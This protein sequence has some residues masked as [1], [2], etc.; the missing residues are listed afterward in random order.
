MSAERIHQLYMRRAFELALNGKGNVATNPLVGAVLVADEKIIGEG[1]FSAFGNPHAEVEAVRSV[2]PE[3]RHLIASSTLYVSLE[4][5]NFY[6]KTPAC[7][8]LILNHKIPALV[9]STKDFTPGLAGSSLFFLQK[10]GI[11]VLDEILPGMGAQ[12]AASRNTVVTKNRPF[13]TLKWALSTDGFITKPDKQIAITSPTTQR[14]VHKLRKENDA[15]L[16]GA[17][18]ATVDNPR[19][20]NRLYFGNHPLRVVIDPNLRV[21]MDRHLF[22]DGATTLLVT[23]TQQKDVLYPPQV[24]IL[25][26]DFRDAHWLKALLNLL[27]EKYTVGNL[28]VEGGTTTLQ[29]FIDQKLWDQAYALTGNKALLGGVPQPVL[30]EGYVQT[31]LNLGEDDLIIIQRTDFEEQSN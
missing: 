30:N 24:E 20:N 28:L 27:V 16:V 17:T 15:I 11:S 4:P 14:F 6:G 7:T 13:I 1:W 5:C 3:N 8:Q 31:K 10:H 2:R 22:N 26:F 21:P 23:D 29:H 25:R 18:T 12:L 9:V 19:L